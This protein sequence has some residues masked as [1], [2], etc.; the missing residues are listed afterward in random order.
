[1]KPLAV[2]SVL[3]SILPLCSAVCVPVTVEA[4][5]VVVGGGYSGVTSAYQLHQAGI[6][7]VVL[8]ASDSLGGKSR[9]KSLGGN[10][11]IEL[12]ATWI[13]NTTQPCVYELTQRFGLETAAQYFEGMNVFQGSDGQMVQVPIES[14]FNTNDTETAMLE[15][16]ALETLHNA[17]ME[18][19]LRRFDVFPADQDVSVATWLAGHEFGQSD[20]VA[21]V[22]KHLTTAL[23]GR[24]SEEIGIHYLMDYI[25]SGGGLESL[26]TDGQ[27][28]AQYLK[29]K[30]GTTSIITSMAATLPPDSIHLSSPVVSIDTTEPGYAILTTDSAQ[31]FRAKKV[32]LAI[33]TNTY[34]YIVF[35]PPLP[36]RKQHILSNTKPG[37]YT[38]AILS[39]GSP[40]WREAK[41]SGKFISRAAGPVCFSWDTSDLAAEQ[42]SLAVF[43]AGDAAAEW[44]KLPNEAAKKT[45]LVDHLVVLAGG[46]E[47]ARA[48]VDF[49]FAEWM[50][51][52]WHEGAPTGAMGPGLLREYGDVLRTPIGRLHF[53]GGETAFEW[54]GY[55]EGAVR[56]GQRVAQE[57]TEAL[58]GNRRGINT[59]FHI[60]PQSAGQ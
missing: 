25:K 21:D 53:G 4:D 9:S 34:K 31:R 55:L 45:A 19:D 54:K 30:K 16:W 2:L 52:D 56:A 47:E 43:V 18:V 14:N 13:N 32:I 12:G 57:V 20:H 40:W 29:I 60:W 38:K 17:S 6:H 22:I 3:L 49:N 51:E 36:A 48:L 39:Y 50:V 28:G 5:V 7:T 33:P 37:I 15:G 44:Q 24:E 26:S 46:M 58:E 59:G 35:T 8:E 11:V 27:V 10:K 1:M 23:I 42:Y 41:L